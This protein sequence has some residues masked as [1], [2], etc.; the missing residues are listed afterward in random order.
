MF[1]I[2]RHSQ[3]VAC[4]HF[5]VLSVILSLTP[6]SFMSYLT[7]SIHLLFT[8]PLPFHPAIFIFILIFIYIRAFFF[9]HNTT[10]DQHSR[11]PF[12]FSI[13]GTI[14]NLP[15]MYS[16]LTISSSVTPHRPLNIPILCMQS[17]FIHLLRTVTQL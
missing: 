11:R 14:F 10:N 12:N 1:L 15:L 3:Y 8:H 17:L 9:S 7:H 2:R 6:F 16:I 13:T 4:F 5:S